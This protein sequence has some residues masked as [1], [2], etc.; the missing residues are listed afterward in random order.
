MRNLFF[1]LMISLFICCSPVCALGVNKSK[2]DS[3]HQFFFERFEITYRHPGNFI[4]NPDNIMFL[5][6]DDN[7]GFSYTSN[8]SGMGSV[9]PYRIEVGVQKTWLGFNTNRSVY[10]N[11]KQHK[12]QCIKSLDRILKDLNRDFLPTLKLDQPDYSAK[13]AA[14]NCAIFFAYSYRQELLN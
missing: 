12:T 14:I 9:D 10:T 6:F 8:L 3:C 13:E 4:G 5:E 2:G 7:K 1:P 11:C